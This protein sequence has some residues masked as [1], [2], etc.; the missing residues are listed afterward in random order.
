MTKVFIDSRRDL[1]ERAF[2]AL[3]S[4]EF[5]GEALTATQFAYEYDKNLPEDQ[6]LDIPL[7][8]LNLVNGV[9]SHKTELD[10]VIESKLKAGWSLSRLTL[11]D[12]NL[13]RLGLYE[14]NYFDET[15]DRVAVNEI[16]EIAKKYS[17]DTS[18]KFV[19]GLLSQFVQN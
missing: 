19:N 1:R 16:I 14:I 4:L 2:Q 15:P 12:K 8:L 10:S 13:L 7:F 9:C 11:T 5:G 18:A 17:D 6:V 3:F